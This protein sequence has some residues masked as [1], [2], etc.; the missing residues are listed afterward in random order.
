MVNTIESLFKK[1]FSA[2]FFK[3]NG[4]AENFEHN[5]KRFRIFSKAQ[6]ASVIKTAP[7]FSAIFSPAEKP[8][9][10]TPPEITTSG[11]KSPESPGE[12]SKRALQNSKS[13]FEGRKTFFLPFGIFI[14]S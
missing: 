10:K 3:R 5:A 7:E 6:E 1:A 8:K 12:F 11:L 13:S 2:D 14:K 4:K 9:F